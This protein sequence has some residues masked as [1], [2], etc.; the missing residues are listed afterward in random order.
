V[1]AIFAA[2]IA[3]MLYGTGAALQQH[4][5]A[6][7]PDTSAGRPSLLLLLL[8][9]PWWLLGF[10][11]EF[12][13]FVVH[14]VALHA[15]P[16]TVVQMLTA[17]SLIFSVAT[18]RVWSGRRL[19]WVTWAACLAVVAGIGAFVAL[20]SP[21]LSVGHAL[22]RHAGLA[23][24]CLGVSAAP[25]AAAGLAAAGRRRAILLA[26]AAGLADT[27]MAVVTMAFT[28]SLGHGINGIVTA[29]PAY[30]L[31]FVG[32]CSVLLTQTAY[33]AGRPMITL[34]VITVVTPV[35]SLA[36]G[37]A[38]LGETT[39]LSTVNAAA[40][41]AA[42]LVTVAG[43]IV[44]ARL[45]VHQE[46]SASPEPVARPEL[47][48][49]PELVAHAGPAARSEPVARPELV[50]HAGPAARSGLV[51][52]PELVAHAG[53]AAEPERAARPASSGRPSRADR[54]VTAIHPRPAATPVPRPSHRPQLP[55]Q[56]RPFHRPHRPRSPRVGP[57]TREFL[58]GASVPAVWN[59]AFWAFPA[60]DTSPDD[61]PSRPRADCA[62]SCR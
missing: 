12:G 56:R 38:L 19:G 10:V 26:L 43:L 48:A 40:V 47:A 9:R 25:F 20:T 34:P 7:A 29:W 22:P 35:A 5:A 14:A 11:G 4:Q 3:A 8:R 36:A 44:L 17:S 15:G 55:H 2:V 32:P 53:P 59:L 21:G 13:G 57:L 51:A 6:G 37:V 46:P 52:R 28:H 61:Q 30:A 39:R 60:G 41:C 45:A 33:Q 18:V 1:T 27:G 42:V 31:V 23:A 62:T 54:P 58:A 24:L 49:R 16:L 50:A